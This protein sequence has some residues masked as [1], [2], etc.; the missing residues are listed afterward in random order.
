MAFYTKSGDKGFTLLPG[1]D[2]SPPLRVR[3]DD[4]RLVALGEI[5]ALNAALGLCA[6][7]AD[8]VGHAAIAAHVRTV[9]E[10]LFVVGSAV[11]AAAGGRK[12]AP[13]RLRSSSVARLEKNI[14]AISAALPELK[15][16]I[17]SGGCEL[18]A[19]LHAA[20]AA[21]RRTER[22]LV[23]GVDLTSHAPRTQAAGAVVGRYVNRLSD[24]LFALARL[25]NHDA[26]VEET[27]WKP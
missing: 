22:A 16:F 4:P 2:G 1:P 5:D 13:L 23:A 20:R 3:K 11:A 17:L 21:T 24:F 7:E 6:T 8:R 9:Q 15:N 27:V 19:R 18:A 12:K 14:D 10:E 26:G 25:A